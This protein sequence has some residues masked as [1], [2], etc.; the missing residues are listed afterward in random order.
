[1]RQGWGDYD[2]GAKRLGDYYLLVH[3]HWDGVESGLKQGS[4]EDRR[5]RE[6]A[7]LIMERSG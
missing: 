2:I 1:M 7:S 4:Q 5:F 3:L 6:K